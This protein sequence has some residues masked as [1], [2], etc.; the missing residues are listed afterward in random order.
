VVL[1]SIRPIS[2][3]SRGEDGGGWNPAH[4]IKAHRRILTSRRTGARSIGEI[5]IS[6]GT[7]LFEGDIVGTSGTVDVP[8]RIDRLDASVA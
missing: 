1:D 7:L 5:G 6:D 4:L 8:S 3:S 2:R